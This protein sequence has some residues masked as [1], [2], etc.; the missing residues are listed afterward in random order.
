MQVEHRLR[1]PLNEV[2][3]FGPDEAIETYFPGRADVSFF[4]AQRLII[5]T[6][7]GD[8]RNPTR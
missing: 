7:A 8:H 6:V 1:R 5:A 4:G 3:H 2:I